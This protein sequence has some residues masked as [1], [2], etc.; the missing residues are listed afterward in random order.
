MPILTN[1]VDPF[2]FW[3]TP[4]AE[5]HALYRLKLR[6]TATTLDGA[7]PDEGSPPAAPKQATATADAT[8]TVTR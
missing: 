5:A 4:E 2:V 3:P 7:K 6:S 1:I 8:L